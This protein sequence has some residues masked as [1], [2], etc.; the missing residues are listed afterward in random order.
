[1]PQAATEPPEPEQISSNEELYLTGVHLEQYRH[2]TRSPE[3]Y[4]TE[5]IRREPDDARANN[6]L[7]LQSMRRGDFREAEQCFRRAVGRLT[8][9]NPNPYDGE[10]YYNLGLSLRYQSRDDEAYSAFYKATWNQAWQAPAYY[11]LAAI[12]CRRSDYG[13]ALEH[14]DRALRTNV[15]H[16]KARNLK[17]H[18]LRILGREAEASEVVRGTSE[19]DPLDFWAKFEAALLPGGGRQHLDAL[20]TVM[21]NNA[22]N[23]LDLA[24][25]LLLLGSFAAVADLLEAYQ[26]GVENDAYLPM[27]RYTLAHTLS[28]LGDLSKAEASYRKARETTPDYCFPV[29]LEEM[30][31]LEAAIAHDADDARAHY[32]LG[33]LLY[34]K[35]RRR[36]A[37]VHWENA[38][39][40]E[41]DFSVPWRNLGIACYNIEHNAARALS[42]YENA[43]RANPA[44]ARLLYEMDQLRKRTG[45][46]PHD[47]LR[48]LE[49]DP[50]LVNQRDDLTVELV[51]L[52]NQID[53]SERALEILTRRRFHPWEGGEGLVSGQY[54]I[55]CLQLG[56][57]ALK[58]GDFAEALRHF[59]AAR[60]YPQNLG[61]GKHLLLRETHID[62]LRGFA[63]S[64]L[65]KKSR[66]RR[67]VDP[68]RGERFTG[69]NLF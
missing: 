64:N 57:R 51:T 28:R 40:L 58:A 2:A 5:A 45:A 8:R 21:R 1:M 9:R 27:V 37:I 39:R 36:E 53:Q 31:V 54:A 23:V 14:A 41:P 10:P 30:L 52:Y 44:D 13:A 19:L 29:R 16:L 65:G 6:A 38:C 4:W 32:Y 3:A 68:C 66:R 69:H 48:I 62:F 25:D 55:A 56:C 63:L 43:R 33:N 17:A 12:D 15:D 24:F 47:R 22:G 26:E 42:S 20:F 35:G 67:P 61:E 46:N 60:T 59:V 49:A 7:G 50:A 18:V 34:D 11:E